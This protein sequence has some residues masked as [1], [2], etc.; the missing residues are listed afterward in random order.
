MAGSFPLKTA[1]TS[2][3]ISNYKYVPGAEQFTPVENWL[4]FIVGNWP[5]F[6]SD[7]LPESLLFVLPAHEN[8][9]PLSHLFFP[10][11][12]VSLETYLVR[13]VMSRPP[14]TVEPFTL[15]LDAALT[16]RTAAIRHLP[17]VETG[18]L[19]RL[20]TGRDIQRC[21]PSRLIPISEVGYNRVFEGTTV[22]R[23]MTREPLSVEP[24]L[25]LSAT[26]ALMQQSRFGCLPVVEDAAVVG[27]LTGSDLVDTLNRIL[28]GQNPIRFPEES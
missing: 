22:E 23:I 6:P 16:L 10:G 14:I 2:Y 26:I 8:L 1:I 12:Y 21:A 25:P 18:L 9:F 20:L 13:H 19:V 15:L 24:D 17:V 7:T 11:G 5:G 27:I 3:T 4:Y 28:T